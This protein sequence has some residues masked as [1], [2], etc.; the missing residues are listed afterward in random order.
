MVELARPAQSINSNKESLSTKTS[1]AE[2]NKPNGRS[3]LTN[4]VTSVATMQF[5][6]GSSCD[7]TVQVSDLNGK[8]LLVKKG[9]ST[10]GLNTEKLNVQHFAP[11]MYFIV[12]TNNKGDKQSFK[13]LKQ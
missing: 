8:I 4:P 13:L 10:P 7:Y 2:L 11:G 9:K 6:A 12:L 5:Y 3:T 1:M